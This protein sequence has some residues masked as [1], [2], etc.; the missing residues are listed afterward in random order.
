MV[1]SM[2]TF[3]I[4]QDKAEVNRIKGANDTALSGAVLKLVAEYR[5]LPGASGSTPEPGPSDVLGWCGAALPRGYW[6]INE[7][8]QKSSLDILNSNSDMGGISTLF[9]QSEPGKD[10]K[11]KDWVESDTDEQ[12]MIFIPFRSILKIHTI[13]LTSLPSSGGDSEEVGRP[14][15]LK[16][17]TNR[18]NIVG[19]DE[20]E[21]IT[22][23]QEVEITPESW[24][25]KGDKKS[26]TIVINTRFVKFQSTSS[27]I[28]FV[29][30]GE[31]G[32][33]KTRIDR[34]KIIG[35]A[36]EKREMGKLEKVK[37]V[38]G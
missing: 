37:D 17:Y 18:P 34:I 16:L 29:E 35:E 15:K 13:H 38:L 8:I 28:L 12:L 25:E 24:D 10:P 1:N 5:K 6:D 30:E 27:L 4:F 26:G 14:T 2:P 23:T 21:D 11:A 32:C 36:G 31:D 22:P 9:E 20:A 19:F 7:E 3:L 33:E